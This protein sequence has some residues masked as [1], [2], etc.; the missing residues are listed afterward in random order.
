MWFPFERPECEGLR[1]VLIDDFSR[2]SR[3]SVETETARRRLVHWG[4]R[5]V[6]VTDGI[7][8]SSKGHKMLSGF[9]A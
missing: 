3:D 4:V 8:T 2:L 7:D 1:E 9:K 6:G 5:L